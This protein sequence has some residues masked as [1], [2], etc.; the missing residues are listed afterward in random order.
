[1]H[2]ECRVGYRVGVKLQKML[3]V[4]KVLTHICQWLELQSSLAGSPLFLQRATLS[5]ECL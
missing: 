4:Q 2:S 1:M 3:V 5:G